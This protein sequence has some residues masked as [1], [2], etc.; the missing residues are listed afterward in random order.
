MLTHVTSGH[1]KK[2]GKGRP[3]IRVDVKNEPVFEIE[4]LDEYSNSLQSKDNIERERFSLTKDEFV[5]VESLD[6]DN[7]ENIVKMDIETYRKRIKEDTEVT[8]SSTMSGSKDGKVSKKKVK[9]K[10]LVNKPEN[11]LF[12]ET[13]VELKIDNDKGAESTDSEEIIDTAID[14]ID[15][16]LITDSDT[17]EEGD[18][19]SIP[20]QPRTEV[21]KELIEQPQKVSS[22][23][24][25]PEPEHE[26]AQYQEQEQEWAHE[27]EPGS[28]EP[29][30]GSINQSINTILSNLYDEPPNK[31]HELKT[32]PLEQVPEPLEH[33]G[34]MDETNVLKEIFGI[35]GED[36]FSGILNF[37]QNV[38]DLQ[39]V[40]MPTGDR[41]LESAEPS[42]SKTL[43]DPCSPP[44]GTLVS[45]TSPSN[46][47]RNVIETENEKLKDKLK[48]Y[49][50]TIVANKEKMAKYKASLSKVDKRYAAK[51]L[52][53]TK[54]EQK[55]EELEA[56]NQKITKRYH[57]SVDEMGDKE[58]AL[59]RI[60]ADSAIKQQKI[61]KLEETLKKKHELEQA[62]KDNNLGWKSL[63]V[64][65]K[66]TQIKELESL[67]RGKEESLSVKLE[68]IMTLEVESNQKDVRYVQ[69]K[70]LMD[71][72]E[73]KFEA[74]K[75]LT[76]ELRVKN[77]N[78]E[79]Y[80]LQKTYTTNPEVTERMQQLEA[81]LKHLQEE[82]A[83]LN[84][85]SHVAIIQVL[86]EKENAIQLE[87]K[88]CALLIREEAEA[89]R[90]KISNL[91]LQNYDL[92][93]QIQYLPILQN[94]IKQ[95]EDQLKGGPESAESVQEDQSG[96]SSSMFN[97]YDTGMTSSWVHNI[98]PN[99]SLLSSMLQSQ[100]DEIQ[101]RPGTAQ[102]NSTS[103]SKT[104]SLVNDIAENPISD[105]ES[106][107]KLNLP[108]I[109]LQK[110]SSLCSASFN[111]NQT[112]WSDV[113]DNE[114]DQTAITDGLLNLS[115]KEMQ[116]PSF[117]STIP[118]IG[119][120]PTRDE[121]SSISSSTPSPAHRS[122]NS[123]PSPKHKTA[124]S[125][126]SPVRPMDGSH[127]N[128]AVPKQEATPQESIASEVE[129]IA[130]DP[131]ESKADLSLNPMVSMSSSPAP[132]TSVR[133]D[134]STES[135][136]SSSI[137]KTEIKTEPKQTNADTEYRTDEFGNDE[138][139]ITGLEKEVKA[140]PDP[141]FKP[142]SP[143]PPSV[144]V[145]EEIPAEPLSHSPV[146][147]PS[148]SEQVTEIRENIQNLNKNDGDEVYKKNLS[149]IRTLINKVEKKKTKSIEK[150][151]LKRKEKKERKLRKKKK[152]EQ[153][154]KR[155]S[156]K[157]VDDV[158]PDISVNDHID[159]ATGSKNVLPREAQEEI[160]SDE[161]IVY[162]EE[163]RVTIQSETNIPL[164]AQIEI[165]R[166]MDFRI[167]R[168]CDSP[169][170]EVRPTIDE[171]EA[172]N[173]R[174]DLHS[175][176]E[177]HR[178]S[179][180][181]LIMDKVEKRKSDERK[182]DQ[183]DNSETFIS[184]IEKENDSKSG[185]ADKSRSM[186][187]EQS[188]TSQRS[189]ENNKP[190]KRLNFKDAEN[191]SS[192]AKQIKK[193]DKQIEKIDSK[194]R[195]RYSGKERREY[196]TSRSRSREHPRGRRRF[197]EERR[198]ERRSVSREIQNSDS[199]AQQIERID[200]EIENNDF[201]TRERLIDIR[202]KFDH[203]HSPGDDK[204][205]ENYSPKESKEKEY[206]QKKEKGDISKSGG[207]KLASKS[208]VL[209]DLRSTATKE[210]S[211]SS[212][213]D[214][215]SSSKYTPMSDSISGKVRQPHIEQKESKP[216][217]RDNAR[218]DKRSSS[219]D[220]S[221]GSK[222]AS[223]VLK[224]LRSTA[225]KETSRSSSK[226]S[227]SSSKHQTLPETISGK[228]REPHMDQMKSTS[229][230]KDDTR[231][232]KRSSHSKT[233]ES[234][235]RSRSRS[236]SKS[237]T[238]SRSRSR[239]RS[240]SRSHSR[241]RS[242]KYKSTSERSR[243][244]DRSASK[245]FKFHR[246]PHNERRSPN[247]RRSRSWSRRRA[248][249]R[250][251]KKRQAVSNAQEKYLAYKKNMIF[252]E[253]GERK[254]KQQPPMENPNAGE[255]PMLSRN[256]SGVEMYYDHETKAQRVRL[257]GYGANGPPEV[258]VNMMAVDPSIKVHFRTACMTCGFD[259][260]RAT[261]ENHF[262]SGAC[263][264]KAESLAGGGLVFCS[265]CEVT[266][267]HWVQAC[268]LLVSFCFCCWVWGHNFLH[269]QVSQ[270]S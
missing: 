259:I 191:S 215:F 70:N 49:E 225:S 104:D 122:T 199:I 108:S 19:S 252:G 83:S 266:G 201:K 6:L 254:P 25:E 67:L 265:Y 182:I 202:Q 11:N 119:D 140:T 101:E 200:R 96:P 61:A 113:S 114:E 69:M 195:K 235:R 68:T 147:V 15:I 229:A 237:R 71:E 129:N 112:Q 26:W 257:D 21:K 53:L 270:T 81:Q 267:A 157:D 116:P 84:Q 2:H 37:T 165:K 168:Q 161:D 264:R 176:S 150:S 93:S 85:N 124:N 29:E 23:I 232:D 22:A 31:S 111:V 38:V 174:K 207:S 8:G 230:S 213:K 125:T 7:L 126:P 33:N 209:T 20:I 89:T 178:S 214:N 263:S 220:T 258:L 239:T 52:D 197:T 198:E 103:T 177:S 58:K 73:K 47:A 269:H 172:A 79:R 183:S 163:R 18:K 242:R 110:F 216:V 12:L 253:L 109:G 30:T 142:L 175:R 131:I 27:P 40:L 63:Q 188:L 88:K 128:V 66:Q 149:Q 132:E 136:Q 245:D 208:K 171:N 226:D 3:S 24:Q 250:M 13:K 260:G 16:Y 95:L 236:R 64:E 34:T 5:D 48:E 244:R 156:I 139:K 135:S 86:Q 77:E 62:Q 134:S 155:R 54:R 35:E 158:S 76:A 107:K 94:K 193:I 233:N 127:S 123:T 194:T 262:V 222:L 105:H 141:T 78:L 187:R 17:E 4:T 218:H 247:K 167:V 159:K 223:K 205:K 45:L 146:P 36:E 256:H 56:E 43:K 179:L 241:S 28:H 212:S 115:E 10:F 203:S 190:T 240:R 99:F 42:T 91:E 152:K 248:E 219:K 138:K 65:E 117:Q 137:S 55:I 32:G 243:H 217:S 151:L 189:K 72:N 92:M 170:K 173:L 120:T 57:T 59:Q 224:D 74:E 102:S 100:V 130:V 185:D 184:Y 87:K 106:S 181:K 227:P 162:E 160:E 143:L 169:V 234:R 210:T 121:L 228:V 1:T 39:K 50:T 186:S 246:T 231:H 255:L 164:E 44:T 153:K 97:A 14:D 268:P 90:Q 145:S 249:G 118:G 51:K 221:A 238:R 180:S 46:I 75:R 80:M 9:E 98:N 133:K 192:V 148:I 206:Y 166:E 154:E 204:K 251:E 60:K 144:P 211:R 41:L 261:T 82:N 196:K